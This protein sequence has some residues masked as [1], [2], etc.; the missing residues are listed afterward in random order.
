[1]P[2]FTPAYKLLVKLPAGLYQINTLYSLST[3]LTTSIDLGGFDLV[4]ADPTGQIGNILGAP[5]NGLPVCLNAPI[6]VQCR[7]IWGEWGVAWSGYIT[8]AGPSFD[9]QSGFIYRITAG[10]GLKPFSVQTQS[11]DQVAALTISELTNISAS[12]VL[13]YAAKAI[14]FPASKL[15]IDVTV[16]AGSGIQTSIPPA[17]FI[18][19]QQ[20]SWLAVLNG[21]AQ[22]TG[23]ILFADEQGI[24]QYRPI[25]YQKPP[26]RFIPASIVHQSYLANSDEELLTHVE[27]RFSIFPVASAAPV[28]P[29][30]NSALAT[31]LAAWDQQLGQRKLIT[32]MPWIQNVQAAQWAATTLLNQGVAQMGIG[33]V[34]IVGDHAYHVGDTVRLQYAGKDAFIQTVSQQWQW[35]GEWL[36]TL[37]LTFVRDAGSVLATSVHPSKTVLAGLPNPKG[38]TLTLPQQQAQQLADGTGV[39]P[40]TLNLVATNRKNA[41]PAGYDVVGSSQYFANGSIAI[42]NDDGNGQ[43]PT[44]GK[45]GAN[46]QYTIAAQTPVSQGGTLPDTTLLIYDARGGLKPEVVDVTVTSV[47]AVASS[48]TGPA[49]P[50]LP[51]VAAVAQLTNPAPGSGSYASIYVPATQGSTWRDKVMRV[52]MNLLGQPYV[53]NQDQD[54]FDSQGQAIAYSCVGLIYAAMKN[55]GYLA[56][57][58]AEYPSDS[59]LAQLNRG[60][61]WQHI[62]SNLPGSQPF[63]SP[64]AVPQTAQQGDILL[65]SNTVKLPDGDWYGDQGTDASKG[66]VF[67]HAALALGQYNPPAAYWAGGGLPTQTAM[68][69]ANSGGAPTG[70]VLDDFSSSYWAPKLTMVVRPDYS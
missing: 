11:A 44:L 21:V 10:D 39:S 59:Y 3:G 43:H 37:G 60:I 53:F 8:S 56:H 40:I 38:G 51:A 64:L 48:I 65:F 33:Q 28:A 6:S 13:Q 25:D 17:T 1:M 63:L 2:D 19:P 20:S 34:T 36:T 52:A 26:T 24:I 69:T 70:V 55:S 22:F 45:S 47:P 18:S 23:N 35:G 15:N 31:Q 46:G 66:L 61:F 29:T 32:Y 41:V 7:N 5:R 58:T 9:T 67:T 50:P 42:I 30:A 54:P 12:Q 27:V 68:V 14:K 57:L 16:D 62:W 49:P 4:C